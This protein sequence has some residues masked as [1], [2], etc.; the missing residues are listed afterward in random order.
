MHFIGMLAFSL[1]IPMGYA[2]PVTVLSMAIAVIVSGFA[3]YVVSQKT[4]RW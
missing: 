1:A 2:V 4:L 3:L